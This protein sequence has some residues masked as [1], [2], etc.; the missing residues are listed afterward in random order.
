MHLRSDTR[1]KVMRDYSPP[2]A[3][4]QEIDRSPGEQRLPVGAMNSCDRGDALATRSG[5]ILLV[6]VQIRGAP[7]F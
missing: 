4:L 1:L 5:V 3:A 2:S 6:P 7:P